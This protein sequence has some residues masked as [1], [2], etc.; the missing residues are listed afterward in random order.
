MS[1][2]VYAPDGEVGPEPA[3]LA[4]GPNVL[5]GLR[6]GVLDNGKPN[7]GLLLARVGEQL[8][9]RTGATLALVIEKGP[10]ANAATPCTEAVFE[11]LRSECD[12]VLTGSADCGSCTSWSVHDT[13]QL[14]RSGT[15][16]VVATTTRFVELTRRVAAGFGVP[17]ARVA[18]FPH[19]LGSTDDDTII[20]WAD[21]A[22]DEVVALL[23]RPA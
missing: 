15:P 17:E 11:R 18:V 1:I 23:T 10:G 21:A 19:P 8:A 2:T 13:I 6:I 4:P 14:E 7:A 9:A 5:T 12:V 3:A 20:A 22:V 16:T